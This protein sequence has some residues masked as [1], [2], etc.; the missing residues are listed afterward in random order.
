[1]S[2]F[3]DRK[4]SSSDVLS[5][6]SSRTSARCRSCHRRA[7]S[8]PCVFSL[9]SLERCQGVG[10]AD[11]RSRPASR[12]GE[13]RI[14]TPSRHARSAFQS[15]RN[16]CTFQILLEQFVTSCRSRERPCPT[17]NPSNADL[18]PGFRQ[19][20]RGGTKSLR[21]LKPRD[22]IT[23]LGMLSQIAPRRL[24]DLSSLLSLHCDA[25]IISTLTMWTLCH[26]ETIV[27][28]LS[29]IGLPVAG[30]CFHIRRNDVPAT[31]HPK[32]SNSNSTNLRKHGRRQ[33]QRST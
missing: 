9:A 12:L 29:L 30:W 13:Y 28:I 19:L 16:R 5:E 2:G 26:A 8:L 1:M 27:N 33:Y 23:D 31:A 22:S 20:P 21:L 24:R 11:C 32:D 6:Q 17:A 4:P 25:N 10:T 15:F 18:K 14:A 3:V 7:G